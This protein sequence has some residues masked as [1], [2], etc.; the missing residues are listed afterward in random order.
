MPCSTSPI[1][2]GYGFLSRIAR[3][4][5]VN[6]AC[7]VSKPENSRISSG[8]A[9]IG[10]VGASVAAGAKRKRDRSGREISPSPPVP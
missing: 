5:A 3:A 8:G 1:G 2:T 4:N 10:P 9:A 6:S 7:S